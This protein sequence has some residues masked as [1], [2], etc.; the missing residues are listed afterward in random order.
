M[1]RIP[2]GSIVPLALLA[3]LAGCAKKEEC[4]TSRNVRLGWSANHDKDVNMAGGGYRVLYSQSSDLSG[5]GSVDLPYVSGSNPPLTTTLPGLACGT[6]YVRVT[7][8]S[9]LNA[10]GGSTD[11]TVSVQ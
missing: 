11:I 9:A 4:T 8:Y 3:L 7:A 10:T 6:W 1:P 5:A 2:Y